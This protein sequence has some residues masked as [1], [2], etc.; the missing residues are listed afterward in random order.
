GRPAPPLDR[1]RLAQLDE[2]VERA[3]RELGIPGVAISLVQDGKVVHEAGFGVR[4]LGQAAR[5][6]PDTLFMI[7]SNTKA[8]TTLLLA[9]LVAAGRLGWD[10]PVVTIYPAFKLGDADTTRR[11]LVKHLICA[12][13]GMPRQDFEWLFEF[14]HATAQSQIDQLAT[15]KP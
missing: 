9:K 12:C 6:D 11:V 2:F 15:Q 10:T 7:A 5:V 14:G 3:Q 4:E 13:T 1:S 8:L